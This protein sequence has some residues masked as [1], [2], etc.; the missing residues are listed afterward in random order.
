MNDSHLLEELGRTQTVKDVQAAYNQIFEAKRQFSARMRH[1]RQN[2]ERQQAEMECF[3]DDLK[4]ITGLPLNS[5]LFMQ[6]ACMTVSR[7]LARRNKQAED[8]SFLG[9]DW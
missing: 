8:E 4:E 2:K 1:A 6:L 5:P 7:R 3:L 9:E